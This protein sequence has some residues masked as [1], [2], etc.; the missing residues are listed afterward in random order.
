MPVYRYQ[1]R[2]KT[3]KKVTGVLESESESALLDVLRRNELVVVSVKQERAKAT[4]V[5]VAKRVKLEELVIFSRQ[6]ATLIDSGITLVGA[7][8]ILIEQV[9]NPRLKDVVVAVRH[10]VESGL[11]F[12][13][14]L[15]RHPRVFSPFFINMVRAGPGT[16]FITRE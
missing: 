13:E 15:T 10:D 6:L 8:R 11:S 1:A 16:R 4:K 12:C 5:S 14:S 2:D 3:G 9:E 7:L